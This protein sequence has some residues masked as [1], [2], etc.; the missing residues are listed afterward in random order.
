M[1]T[2]KFKDG[3]HNGMPVFLADIDGKTAHV[4]EV[5]TESELAQGAAECGYCG[6]GFHA[7]FPPDLVGDL[8]YCGPNISGDIPIACPNPDCGAKGFVV[9]NC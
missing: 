4:D 6:A 7:V 1:Q 8:Q 5:R 9:V 3:L 2:I